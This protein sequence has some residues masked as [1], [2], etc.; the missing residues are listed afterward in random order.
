MMK[1]KTAK[2]LSILLLLLAISEVGAQ[3]AGTLTFTYNQPT[4]ASPTVTGGSKAPLVF[5]QTSLALLKQVIK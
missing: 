2:I 3:T 1:F 4:P 5:S